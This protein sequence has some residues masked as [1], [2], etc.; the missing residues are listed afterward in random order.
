MLT[1]TYTSRAVFL[2]LL[3][4]LHQPWTAGF[5]AP[6]AANPRALTMHQMCHMMASHD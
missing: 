4:V 2:A 1:Y 6:E 3:A 5:C